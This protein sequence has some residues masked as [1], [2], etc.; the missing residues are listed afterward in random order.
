MIT[1]VERGTLA[2]T[3]SYVLTGSEDDKSFHAESIEIVTNH[4]SLSYAM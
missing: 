3:A 2:A 1:S 4:S